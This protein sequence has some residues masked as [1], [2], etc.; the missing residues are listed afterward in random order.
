[1]SGEYP[2]SVAEHSSTAGT[3]LQ[4]VGRPGPKLSTLQK[5]A[6]RE[7]REYTDITGNMLEGL[8]NASPFSQL[9]HSECNKG[10]PYF[11]PE[12]QETR[13]LGEKIL[14]TFDPGYIFYF[15]DKEG[16]QIVSEF[17]AFI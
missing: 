10:N 6:L 17:S 12:Q 16:L 13:S 15:R 4:H 5:C 3:S 8:L 7:K 11:C 14:V 9:W 2:R 1:M